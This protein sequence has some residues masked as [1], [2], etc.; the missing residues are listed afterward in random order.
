MYVGHPV[1]G[2]PTVL[3][4]MSRTEHILKEIDSCHKSAQSASASS[5]RRIQPYQERG[6]EENQRTWLDNI[7]QWTELMNLERVLQA[8]DN[9]S[10]W[11]RTMVRSTL[12]SRMTEVKSVLTKTFYEKHTVFLKWIDD[13]DWRNFLRLASSL[14]HY[15]SRGEFYC[16][17]VITETIH[18]IALQWGVGDAERMKTVH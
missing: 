8:T 9:S 10:Q 17:T 18:H 4:P 15:W 16:G 13:V 7:I 14:P 6:K 2:R 5:A 3:F 11:I 12:G 1:R